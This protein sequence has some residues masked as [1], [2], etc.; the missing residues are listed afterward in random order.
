MQFGKTSVL[1]I[2]FLM[3]LSFAVTQANVSIVRDVPTEIVTPEPSSNP[4]QGVSRAI[5]DGATKIYIVEKDSRWADDSGKRYEN[6]HLWFPLNTVI[7][8]P[9]LGVWDT[10]FVWSS[11]ITGL[12]DLTPENLGAV[13]AVFTNTWELC[14]AYPPNGYWYPAYYSDASATAYPGTPGVNIAEGI[15]THSVLVE[16]GTATW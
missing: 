1:V 9:D 3:L 11:L 2:G 16:E 4:D 13:G 14:D 10:T 7:S 8:I 5:Y 15:Y 6:A 12:T